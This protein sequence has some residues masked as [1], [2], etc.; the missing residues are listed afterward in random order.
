MT[1]TLSSSSRLPTMAERSLRP[2]TSRMLNCAWPDHPCVA[3]PWHRKTATTS[4]KSSR[5][6]T[7]LMFQAFYMHCST[8]LLTVVMGE[9]DRVSS[10][11]THSSETHHGRYASQRKGLVAASPNTHKERRTSLKRI[12]NHRQGRWSTQA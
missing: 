12:T 5:A 9:K 8:H 2:G 3:I 4:F 11:R 7:S 6:A 10:Y 1:T